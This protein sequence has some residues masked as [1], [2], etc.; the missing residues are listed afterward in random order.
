M[1]QP[2][3]TS[4]ILKHRSI[5]EDLPVF[6]E[7]ELHHGIPL[8]IP[9]RRVF[10]EESQEEA[11]N[12]YRLKGILRHAQARLDPTPVEIAPVE[13]TPLQPVRV[14]ASEYTGKPTETTDHAGTP[15]DQ[16]KPSWQ[17]QMEA[18]V[19]RAREEAYEEGYAAAREAL[20]VEFEEVAQ[21]IQNDVRRLHELCASFITD[22]EPALVNLAFEVAQAILDA[23][24]PSG[25]KGVSA[26]TISE[27]IEQMAGSGLIEVSL[28]PVDF[29]RLQEAGTVEQLESLHASLRW[30]P[31]PELKQGDWFVQSPVAMIRH[32]EKEMIDALKSRIGLLTAVQSRSD[33][34]KER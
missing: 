33:K 10:S 32:I 3:S 16:L 25:I 8:R 11:G 1:D 4:R 19:A 30:E 24:L 27:S 7:P 21:T 12:A 20:E 34:K 15:G 18:E 26:R 17:E 14:D 23:P 9:G 22:A 5:E 28:H 29:L 6:S 2:A 31:N 13:F